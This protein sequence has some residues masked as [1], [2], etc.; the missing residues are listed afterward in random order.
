MSSG[1]YMGPPPMPAALASRA[2][3]HVK[4]KAAT[5]LGVIS[6]LSCTPVLAL[7]PTPSQCIGLQRK[8][9]WVCPCLLN[10]VARDALKTKFMFLN[11]VS[12]HQATCLS[13]LH[14]QAQSQRRLL[15]M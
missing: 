11:G 9:Y 6:N 7:L 10:E 3:R 12:A 5:V 13:P 8:L 1:R 14:P 15:Y 2:H 4:T